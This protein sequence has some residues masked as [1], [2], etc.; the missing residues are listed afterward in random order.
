MLLYWT[1]KHMVHQFVAHDHHV[2]TIRRDQ[3][4]TRWL[5]L[6]ACIQGSINGIACGQGCS[7][8]HLYWHV[9]PYKRLMLQAHTTGLWAVSSLLPV[10]QCCPE[11]V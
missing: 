4:F 8:D 6:A 10:W 3:L 9:P 1:C 7:L 2:M 11:E 5:T